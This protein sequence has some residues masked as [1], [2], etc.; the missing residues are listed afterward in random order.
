MEN[1]DESALATQGNGDSAVTAERVQAQVQ[2]IQ[3]V[4]KSVMKRDT[5]YGKIKGCGDALVLFKPGAETLISTFQ[6]VAD[7]IIEEI[8][9]EDGV[10]YRI[11]CKMYTRSGVYLGAGVGEGSTRETKYLWRSAI[12]DAEYDDTPADKRR[13]K[14]LRDGKSFKQV[15]TNTADVAN[16]VL[17]MTHKRAMVAG[18]LLVTGASDIFTQDLEEG[19]GAT[20]DDSKDKGTQGK[21]QKKD[22]P[23]AN[24]DEK[25]GPADTLLEELEEFC[26]SEL[27]M[28]EVLKDI[29]GF[30]GNNGLIYLTVDKVPNAKPGWLGKTLNKLRELVKSGDYVPF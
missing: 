5:H 14:Y 29:S 18:V 3:K 15:M 26:G 19:G 6:L 16:T 30:E 22:T 2:L 25:L 4:M 21:V 9:T 10:T 17:K 24:G 7:P 23:P 28:N 13:L 8:P 12:C 11:M 1:S 27:D 20:T